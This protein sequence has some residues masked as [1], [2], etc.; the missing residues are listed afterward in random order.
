MSLFSSR[1][2][3]VSAIC[4]SGIRNIEGGSGP[5][6]VNLPYLSVTASLQFLMAV[7]ERI[8]AAIDSD[9]LMQ[10]ETISLTLIILG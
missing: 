6:G 7:P 9:K 1:K 8:W 2:F 5:A 10:V 4:I 3:A